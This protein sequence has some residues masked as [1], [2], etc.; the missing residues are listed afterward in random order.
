MMAPKKANEDDFNNFKLFVETLKTR[1]DALEYENASLKERL[2]VL[3]G[4][5]HNS[6]AVNQMNWSAIATNQKNK[7]RVE[8]DAMNAIGAMHKDKE[9]R[10]KNIII[11]GLPISNKSDGS[12]RKEEDRHQVEDLFEEIGVEKN[13]IKRIYRFKTKKDANTADASKQIKSG[14]ILVELNSKDDQLITLKSAKKLK[15][16]KR[17]TKVFINPDQNEAERNQTRDLVKERNEK[18]DQ[19]KNKGTLNKPFRYGIRDNRVVEINVEKR[20]K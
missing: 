3:E 16:T 10:D 14:P 13:K 9:K 2:S 20:T 5:N 15:D 19:L 1:I 11:V 18:N 12:Q 8:L 4:N 6:S 7:S 17:F